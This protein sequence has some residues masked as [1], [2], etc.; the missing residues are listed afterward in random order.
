MVQNMATRWL[1]S[2]IQKTSR[3]HSFTFAED[4]VK[5]FHTF[6][7]YVSHQFGCCCKTVFKELFKHFNK[8]KVINKMSN[9]PF[10]GR[11]CSAWR[12]VYSID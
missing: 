12:L 2:H 4:V 6:S 10:S 3:M 11:G 1:C 9:A 8:F 7:S 5:I